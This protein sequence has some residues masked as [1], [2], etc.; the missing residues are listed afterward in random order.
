MG[1]PVVATRVGGISDLLTH[2]ENALLVP[3]D[4]D[5]AM[6]DAILRLLHDPDLAG[7]LSAGGRRVAEQCSWNEAA[8]RWQELLA[9]VTQTSTNHAVGGRVA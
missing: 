2:N 5:Q 4:D 8:S 1:L 3:D 7:R 9:E 6:A